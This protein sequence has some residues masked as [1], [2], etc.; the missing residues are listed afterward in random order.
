VPEQKI[1]FF[2]TSDSASTGLQ[3]T[4]T[5]PGSRFRRFLPTLVRQYPGGGG[6]GGGWGGGGVFF[7][8]FLLFWVFVFFFFFFF[9]LLCFLFG[10]L[11]F[12]TDSGAVPG[13]RTP[14]VVGLSI[15]QFVWRTRFHP[16]V[17]RTLFTLRGSPNTIYK[18][19][20]RRPQHGPSRAP[21]RSRPPALSRTHSP[22]TR[23]N[24]HANGGVPRSTG[25]RWR[26]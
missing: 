18:S 4:R 24:F 9:F 26:L 23:L 5:F 17:R 15:D 6:G 25:H 12:V 14:V 21:R 19:H 10:A 7:V 8:E 3:P 20:R 2:Q 11:I 1:S 22:P 13:L 16:R